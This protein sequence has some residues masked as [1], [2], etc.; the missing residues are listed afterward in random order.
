MFVGG[1]W[2]WR[3]FYFSP[4]VVGE[5]WVCC[6]RWCCGCD[7]SLL[8][9]ISLVFRKSLSCVQL[10]NTRVPS[11]QFWCFT[12]VITNFGTSSPPWEDLCSYKVESLSWGVL[13]FLKKITYWVKGIKLWIKL[14]QNNLPVILPVTDGGKFVQALQEEGW[15]NSLVPSG[16]KGKGVKKPEGPCWQGSE[17]APLLLY[18]IMKYPE[19]AD[20]V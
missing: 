1:Y 20:I 2:R 11:M 15:T 17:F 19:K 12:V 9:M 13:F 8:M 6:S 4:L 5:T 7:S 14:H 10:A 16:A 3:V 18:F